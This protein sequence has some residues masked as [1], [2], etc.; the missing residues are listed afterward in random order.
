MREEILFAANC[1]LGRRK[2]LASVKGL[3]ARNSHFAALQS[4]AKRTRELLEYK[5]ESSRTG[6]FLALAMMPSDGSA[7]ERPVMLEELIRVLTALEAAAAMNI[8]PLAKRGRR[9]DTASLPEGF[10]CALAILFRMFTGTVPPTGI[11][12]HFHRFLSAFL[13][14]VGDP[15]GEESIA[16]AIAKGR[17]RS[18]KEDGAKSPFARL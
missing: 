17:T 3:T 7:L 18:L 10:V 13:V 11:D 16:A 15:K 12:T 9:P 5:A 2:A 4:A 8:E 6:A 14:A 1:H